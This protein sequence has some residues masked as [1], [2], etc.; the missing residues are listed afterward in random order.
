MKKSLIALFTA[1]LLCLSIVPVQAEEGLKA[2]FSSKGVPQSDSLNTSAFVKVKG[3]DDATYK[4]GFI[5]LIRPNAGASYFDFQTT[6][7]MNKICERFTQYIGIARILTAGNT[8]ATSELNASNVRGEF[9]ITVMYP[10]SFS[11]P[12]QFEQGS[13]MYGFSDESKLIFAEVGTRSVTVNGNTKTLKIKIKI[14]KGE[15]DYVT[16]ADLEE[17]ISTYLNDIV[18]TC[19]GVS[20]ST[21][22]SFPVSSS[23][24][25]FTSISTPGGELLST[26]NY[27]STHNSSV[28]VNVIG[29]E[30]KIV[31]ASAKSYDADEN[32][33]DAEVAVTIVD[34]SLVVSGKVP[35][36]VAN[37]VV[38]YICADGKS[39]SASINKVDNA[40]IKP[41]DV[42]IDSTTYTF[43]IDGLSIIPSDV[44]VTK[45]KKPVV[46]KALSDTATNEEKEA[47]DKLISDIQ[48]NASAIGLRAAAAN[49]IATKVN[50]NTGEIETIG[51]V[52]DNGEIIS[53]KSDVTMDAIAAAGI[54]FDENIHEIV[55]VIQPYLD[56]KVLDIKIDI[57]DGTTVTEWTGDIKPKYN[58]IAVRKDVGSE[59]VPEIITE[60]DAGTKNAAV[61]KTDLALEV[62]SNVQLL[63]P[64]PENMF[65]A[66]ASNFFVVHSHVDNDNIEKT[67]YYRAT[68]TGDNPKLANFTTPNGFS[69][70]VFFSDPRNTLIQYPD[71]TSVVYDFANIEEEL[72]VASKSGSKF[73]GWK[74]VDLNGDAVP[75]VDDIYLSM[76]DELLTLLNG[77]SFLALPKFKSTTTISN[78][79]IS[80]DKTH[81]CPFVDIAVTDYFHDAVEWATE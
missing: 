76:S 53:G 40:F 70:F 34:N 68:I 72:P 19:S 30:N 24:D 52:V 5:D 62:S 47:A 71:G 59:G 38:T 32:E 33:V 65:I 61:I 46:A 8:L 49:K 13:N 43:D 55:M 31:S 50:E 54:T 6:L 35:T 73:L 44:T 58:V 3:N 45:L 64:L 15:Q 67:Y 42:N 66:S 27:Q 26:I 17:N 7:D 2:V 18:L 75:G 51:I 60:G 48:E 10:T 37:I 28:G 22:G 29:I 4:E 57:N 41:N 63:I 69:E 74:I 20:T 9:T 25:G 23:L 56:I 16:V 36:T 14:Q 78:D 77:Q 81:V 11:V 12:N 79:T 39:Y 21:V 80:A 1:L